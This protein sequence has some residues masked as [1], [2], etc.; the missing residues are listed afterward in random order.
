M[1]QR[2]LFDPGNRPEV[3]AAKVARTG[4]REERFYKFHEE[5]PHVY[6]ELVR[7]A[8]ALVSRGLPNFGVRLL[9]ESMRFDFMISTTKG[10]DD[11][12]LN[13][14]AAPFYARLIMI[15]EP[16]LADVFE[17]REAEVSADFIAWARSGAR[18]ERGRPSVAEDYHDAP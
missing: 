4:T 17:L 16:H 10:R 5:N 3:R 11:F 18:P 7:R 12:K 15:R 14:H 9:W 6:V 13:D 2:G 1:S 8:T